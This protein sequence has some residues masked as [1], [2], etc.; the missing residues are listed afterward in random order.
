MM[1]KDFN[2]NLSANPTFQ[3]VEGEK[4]K[5]KTRAHDLKE[6]KICSKGGKKFE[7]PAATISLQSR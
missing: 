1:E 4:V 6:G 5:K 2:Q 7:E 3:I